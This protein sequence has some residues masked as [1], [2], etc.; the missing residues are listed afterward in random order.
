MAQK[1]IVVKQAKVVDPRSSLH[2]KTLDFLFEDERIQVLPKGK[3]VEHAE[4]FQASNL[5]VSPGWFDVGA[6]FGDP[7]YEHKE[8]LDSGLNAAMHGGF[9]SLAIGPNSFPVVDNKAAVEYL[10]NHNSEHWMEIFALASFSKNLEGEALAEL[11]DLQASGVVGFSHSNTPIKN[12][13]LLKL[14][15]QYAR[16]FSA[17]IQVP[18][19][20]AQLSVGQM[21]EG[22][23]STLIGLKGIPAL[24]ET[25]ALSR[26]IKLAEYAE[27]AIH[28][29]S[30]S[31]KEGVKLLKEALKQDKNISAD[32]AISNLYFTDEALS[33]YN[34]NF[35][36]QPPIRSKEDQ[37][38]LLK[39]LK[40]GTIA[41]VRSQH[42]PQDIESKKCEFDHA[43]FG[44][45]TL[46]ATFGALRKVSQ[47]SI[48]LS[49]LIEILA[50]H[51]RELFGL[52]IPHIE[53]GNVA[54]LSFFD[55]DV[56]WTFELSDIKSKS[57]NSPFIGMPLKGKPLGIF[58]KGTLAWTEE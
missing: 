43:A 32:V 38:A 24:S 58:S 47:K 53:K 28:F 30:I 6:E 55:P 52:E 12:I 19:F 42:T 39:G 57:K 44:A 26:D 48:S 10:L 14:A 51:P 36:T 31:S 54:C 15:L 25:L 3:K 33:N 13:T 21:H 7:G 34:S 46:E 5:H 16:D 27:S 11:F 4:V 37:K 2:G 1:S 40:D 8:D 22:K 9:T 17:P 41:F 49:S 18:S 29:N 20:E 56:E 50:Y 35:K 45:E 23:T